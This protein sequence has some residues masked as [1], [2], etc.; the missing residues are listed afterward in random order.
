MLLNEY[1]ILKQMDNPHIIK[2]FE[3]WKDE[4]FYY[5]VTEYLE[6]GELYKTISKR[7]KFTEKDCAVIVRQILLALNYCHQ[8]GIVH[9]DLKPDNILFESK[10]DDSNCK[11]VDFGF[12]GICKTGKGM[13]EVLGTPLYIAPEIISEK[14]YGAEVDVWSLG[15]ITYF[16]ISGDPPFDGDTRN[17]LFRSIKSGKFSFD[18]KIWRVVSEDCKDFIKKCLV[19]DPKKRESASELLEHKW[20]TKTP[21]IEVDENVIKDSLNNLQLYAQ[22]NK[23]QQGVV[24]FL[25]YKCAQRDEVNK[26]SE[27]FKQIDKNN[28]GKL[29]DKEIAEYI[30]K[31]MGSVNY[32]EVQE[33]FQLLD[34]DKSGY[35]D[36]SEFLSATINK[37]NLIRK[38]ELINMFTQLDS[39]GSG[40]ISK[41]ELRKAFQT[42]GTNKTEEE[43]ESILQEIDKD[44]NEEINFEEFIQAMD[45]VVNPETTHPKAIA[46]VDEKDEE[47]KE[48]QFD[49]L[50][51][52]KEPLPA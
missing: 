2:I 9:R 31:I 22:H 45:T 34:I 11:L 5:I 23:L 43:W 41:K 26:L 28:D 39:D 27:I 19:V 1:N 14:K 6:G 15:V 8:E 36:Y 49:D 47:E 44:G 48:E 29:T 17:E 25:T 40:N 10:S 4:V 24:H 30:K 51:N 21:T 18:S 46:E 38:Q 42:K 12:A 37:K 3:F 16:L 33:I 32:A 20:I 35:I 13:K 52:T 50:H 7:E